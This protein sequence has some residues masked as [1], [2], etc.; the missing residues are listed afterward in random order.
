MWQ[1]EK[2]STISLKSKQHSTGQLSWGCCWNLHA[3]RKFERSVRTGRSVW[4]IWPVAFASDSEISAGFWFY[5]CWGLLI[6]SPVQMILY[7][8]HFLHQVSLYPTI[9]GGTSKVFSVSPANRFFCIL[10]FLEMKK[11]QLAL[12]Q[13]IWLLFNPPFPIVSVFSNFVSKT[14]FLCP[15]HMHTHL[16]VLCAMLCFMLC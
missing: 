2:Q 9:N 6:V 16:D 1:N 7:F 5:L 4:H 13:L 11:A 14:Y 12:Y 15:C 3:P 8:K 10:I